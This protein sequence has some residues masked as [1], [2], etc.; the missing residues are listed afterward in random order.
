MRTDAQWNAAL[1]SDNTAHHRAF[2]NHV[3]GP[4]NI[5]ATEAVLD[6]GSGAGDL[7]AKLAA[8]VPHGSVLGI[9]ASLP[10]IE[11][12]RTRFADAD[13][14]GFVHLRAQDLGQLAPVTFSGGRISGPPFDLAITVATLHWVPG[15]EHPAL[16]RNLCDLLLDGGRFR[17]DFGGAGQIAKVRDI[18]DEESNAVGGSVSPWYFPPAEEVAAR[19]LAAGFEVGDGFVRLVTQRRSVPDL[20]ALTG[21]LDSQVLIAYQPSIDEAAYPEFRERAI[22]RLEQAGPREDGSFDQDYVRVD[23]LVTKPSS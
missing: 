11:G 21:W 2:D 8:A 17:A 19:L 10:L 9:D 23:V 1:Y 14:V 15:E 4:V 16:Y 13:N 20:T 3:L 12:S 5:D 7:T 18:L 6:L 22:A